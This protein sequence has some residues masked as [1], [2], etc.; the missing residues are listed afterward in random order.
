MCKTIGNAF[1]FRAVLSCGIWKQP[2]FCPTASD[3][4]TQ[5]S[6]EAKSKPPQR[7]MI[8]SDFR[9]QNSYFQNELQIIQKSITYRFLASLKPC[10]NAQLFSKQ[11]LGISVM[12]V[13]FTFLKIYYWT[14]NFGVNQ[15]PLSAKI[16]E[17][18]SDWC[19]AERFERNNKFLKFTKWK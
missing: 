13:N 2:F 19:G 12:Y 9:I 15:F 10:N 17:H 5:P 16:S 1:L 4:G 8:G 11:W 6:A 7:K 3:S 14:E 18:A